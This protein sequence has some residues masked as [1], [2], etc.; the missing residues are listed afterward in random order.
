M[1]MGK[2]NEGCDTHVC[3]NTVQGYPF[4]RVCGVSLTMSCVAMVR[5]VA[6]NVAR[7]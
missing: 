6:R 3:R 7:F 4:H 5:V 1:T 2:C